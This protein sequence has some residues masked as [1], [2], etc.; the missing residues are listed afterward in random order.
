VDLK[1]KW[2]FEGGITETSMQKITLQLII[3]GF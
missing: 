2:I 3:R 1:K